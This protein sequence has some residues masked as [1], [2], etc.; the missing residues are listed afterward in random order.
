MIETKNF[1]PITDP[2][3]ICTCGHPKCDKRS[4][5]Q[6][7][8]NMVQIIRSHIKMPMKV[9]SGGRCPYHEEEQGR[10]IPADH[11]RQIGVDIYCAS[12]VLRGAIIKWAIEVG[13]NAIGISDNF[14]HL[15]YREEYTGEF[16]LIWTY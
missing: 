5:S 11:Q 12:S 6:K 3:L 9:T 10:D 4:V 15:G 8:L 2:K 1:N 13:F 16:P 7:V 14:I